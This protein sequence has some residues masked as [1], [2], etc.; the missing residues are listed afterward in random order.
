[1]HSEG[2]GNAIIKFFNEHVSLVSGKDNI[3]VIFFSDTPSDHSAI[4]LCKLGAMFGI[5]GNFDRLFIS[6]S[7]SN[8]N[9][10]WFSE[11]D[12]FTYFPD[13]YTADIGTDNSAVTGFLALSDNSF[14][15]FKEQTYRDPS[16]AYLSGEYQYK[17]D[18]AGNLKK[19]TPVFHI[20][21][22]ASEESPLNNYVMADLSGDKIF[23]SASGVYA[24]YQS[25]NYATTQR[26]LRSRS[27]AIDKTLTA[28]EHLD[29]AVAITHK[30]KYYLA[31]NGHVYVADSLM[32]YQPTDYDAYNYEW[33]FWDNVPAVCWA[34][35]D[36]EL[37]FGCADGRV[38]AFDDDTLYKDTS[39]VY[40]GNGNITT[41]GNAF[42]YDEGID[43]Y[44]KVDRKIVINE[45]TYYVLSVDN[46]NHT[47]SL[48][49]YP[50][51]TTA[52]AV[53]TAVTYTGYIVVEIPVVSEWVTPVFD[54]GVNDATKFLQRITLSLEPELDG[55]LK[56]GFKT[57]NGGREMLAKGIQ[58]YDA[59]ALDFNNFTVDT[60]HRNSYTVPCGAI[61]NYISFYF[62][63]ESATNC[64][65]NNMTVQY[66]INKQ[67]VGVR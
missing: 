24:I 12:D 4:K 60:D 43:N 57:T 37:W 20:T 54:F 8:K 41:N 64:C 14:A 46:T 39:Y 63:S 53:T 5:G 32:K 3:E 47:L 25:E 23:A 29:K 21:S 36:N 22:G 62:R 10:V 44:V 1:M 50:E 42:T 48:K 61:F 65:V 51:D 34:I 9:R 58:F 49:Q 18:D 7:S 52:A 30:G 15:V 67:H 33:Y 66:R 55:K 16:I 17:Y 40:I 13:T 45:H 19:M 35:V 11:A 59:D 2:N 26:L 38:C 28:E 31:V 27:I 6:G 56:F